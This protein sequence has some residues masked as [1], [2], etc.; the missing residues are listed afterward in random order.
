MGLYM[1]FDNVELVPLFDNR[2][3]DK[4]ILFAYNMSGDRLSP[5]SGCISAHK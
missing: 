3:V 2:A 4:I 5:Y 1:C